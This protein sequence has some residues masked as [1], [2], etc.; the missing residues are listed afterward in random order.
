MWLYT[1][2]AQKRK[3]PKLICMAEQWNIIH[4]E[5]ESIINPCY[6]IMIK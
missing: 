2:R 6:S 5:K 3:Q 4:S 1:L